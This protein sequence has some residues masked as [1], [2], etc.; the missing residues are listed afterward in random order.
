MLL[1]LF[2][3]LRLAVWKAISHNAFTMAK[4]AAYSAILSLFPA[5]LVVTTL[6]A[7]TPETNSFS[8]EIRAGFDEILPPDTMALVQSYFQMNHGRSMQV[9]WS[10]SFVSVFAAMGVLLSLMEGFRRAHDVSPHSWGFWRERA[11]ALAL[12]PSCFVPMFFATLLVAF[13]HQIERWMIVNAYHDLRDYVLIAARIAR[14][15]VAVSTTVAVLTLI[16][17][18]GLPGTRG[19]K[20]VLPGAL[21]AAITWFL[22]TLIFGWY[23]TRHADYSLV[24]GPLGA[25]VATLVWLYITSLSVLMGAEFNA[26]VFPLSTMP[27]K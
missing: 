8:G 7:L 11:V 14:W 2:V 15:L 19:W 16:Y 22:A 9:V 20:R 23:V 10:A 13:G 3:Q 21:L 6:L 1:R 27:S 17:H 12:I 26:Q 24:Y 4:A 18:F 25:G 5:V